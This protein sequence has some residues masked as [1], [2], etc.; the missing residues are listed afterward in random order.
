MGSEFA[1][2]DLT[3]FEIEKFRYKYLGDENSA[4]SHNL[5]SYKIEAIPND[6]YSGYSKQIIWMDKAELRPIRIEYYDK[7]GE[8]LKI[9]DFDQYTLYLKKFWRAKVSVM[10]NVQTKKSTV[11][12]WSELEFNKGLT[13]ADFHQNV[14]KRVM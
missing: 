14:L 3:S 5:D 2:E 6:E 8:L 7:K 13:E 1:Y 11:L 4:K 9:Q 10:T 12:E